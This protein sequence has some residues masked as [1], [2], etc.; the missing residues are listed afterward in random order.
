[1][2]P[3]QIVLPHRLAT[4]ELYDRAIKRFHEYEDNHVALRPRCSWNASKTICSF[5]CA[6]PWSYAV[7]SGTM[8]I[9]AVLTISPDKA[10]LTGQVTA[11]GS[12]FN[13][14]A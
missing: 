9:K 11:E 3:I 10:E 8:S 14:Q 4:A 13:S 1:M 12:K 5:N 6:G 7:A 2:K